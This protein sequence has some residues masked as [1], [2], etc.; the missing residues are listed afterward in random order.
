VEGDGG[1]FGG[2]AEDDVEVSDRQQVGLA[3]GQPGARGGA[4][5]LGAV[6]VAARN[7][8]FPLHALWAN[9]VM[10]SQRAVLFEPTWLAAI[11]LPIT[12]RRWQTCHLLDRSE[13]AL[14]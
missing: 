13:R 14:G 7:G 8:K 12:A 10:E 5:A 9:S 11:F 1:E 2:N 3:L 6:P 4:L